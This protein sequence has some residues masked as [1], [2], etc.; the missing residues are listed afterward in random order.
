[1]VHHGGAHWHVLAAGERA[2]Q[3]RAPTDASPDRT[4][5]ETPG[6][7]TAMKTGDMKRNIAI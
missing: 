1:M 2:E 5:W 6:G 4:R 7:R 3:D